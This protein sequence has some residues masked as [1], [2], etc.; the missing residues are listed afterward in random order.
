MIRKMGEKDLQ[1][2]HER[3]NGLSQKDKEFFHPHA[4]T[5][6][7]L[8][9]LLDLTYDSYF[10]KELH[11]ILI[12]YSMLRTF[13]KYEIPTFGGVIWEEYRGRGHGSALL[14]DTLSEAKKLGFTIVKL[15]VYEHN[16][17]AFNLYKKHGFT[18]LGKE[19][20]EIWMEKHLS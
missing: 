1:E 13:G 5:M 14:K 4:F 8:R 19:G 20:D 18:I 10:V 6:A 17:R 3:L 15:K 12:G 7:A 11:N 16:M 9:Q 2:L